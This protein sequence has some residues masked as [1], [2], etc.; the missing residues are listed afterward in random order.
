L[1]EEAPSPS[2]VTTAAAV[3]G[4]LPGAT[5]LDVDDDRDTRELLHV[6]LAES[7]AKPIA[8]SSAAEAREVLRYRSVDV[9]V[10]DV[11]MPNEDGYTFMR[12]LR[13]S[14]EAA[15][16][17]TPALA[18]TGHAGERHARESL[19]AGFQMYAPKPIDP[20]VL[21]RELSRLWR[22]GAISIQHE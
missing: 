8:V 16:A 4:L 7:G 17:F 9:I 12:T 10:C 5:V 2:A 13:A 21:L 11:E 6:L 22:R 14:G 18:L 19:M 15:G 20:P 3:S 1:P